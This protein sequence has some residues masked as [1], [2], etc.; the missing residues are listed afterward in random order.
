MPSRVT[1]GP[2]QSDA[3]IR[4]AV[5]V[6]TNKI[7]D[8]CKDKDCLEDLRVYLNSASQ[9]AVDNAV[10]IRSKSATLLCAVPEVEPVSF[11]RGYYTVDVRFFYKIR[12]EACTLSNQSVPICGLATFDKRVLLFGSEGNAKIFTSERGSCCMSKYVI[13]S[14]NLPTAVVEAVDPII[15]DLK[16]V[17]ACQS[18]PSDCEVLEVPSYIS[19]MFDGPL[20]MDNSGR[21]VFVTLGQF[22]IVR[23]ERDSQLLMPAYDYC[24]P[25]K[26]CVGTGSDDPCTMFSRID[27][28][29]DEFFPPDTISNPEDY[30]DFIEQAGE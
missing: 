4:E 7:Y 16:F 11:N 3:S 30:R 1:P 29:V 8:S 21:R 2:I 24:M 26:E 20:G 13:E 12:G 17:D 6:H 25:D 9:C 27:F 19:D 15:L 5:C 10:S 22:T 28:P 14:S 18:S 23:L